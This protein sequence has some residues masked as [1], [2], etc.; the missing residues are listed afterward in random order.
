MTAENYSLKAPTSL[1]SLTRRCLYHAVSA[2][3]GSYSTHRQ[4]ALVGQLTAFCAEAK[5]ACGCAPE[6]EPV[7]TADDVQRF[8]D[9]NVT[10]KQF[11]SLL[12]G[13]LLRRS[14]D[15]PNL[16]ALQEICYRLYND[17]AETTEDGY[18]KIEMLPPPCSYKLWVIFNVLVG[19]ENSAL[20]GK[21]NFRDLMKRLYELSGLNWTDDPDELANK[22]GCLKFSEYLRIINGYFEKQHL[23]MPLTCEMIE[24]VYDEFVC[25]VQMKGYLIK[26]G[27]VRKNFKRRWFILQRTKL[28]YF[29]S[30][31]VLVKKGEI[32][33]DNTSE[34]KDVP[35]TK[36]FTYAFKLNCVVSGKPFLLL[37]DTQKD[38]HQ[39]MTAI[40]KVLVLTKLAEQ[41]GKDDLYEQSLQCFYTLKYGSPSLSLQVADPELKM[42]D[43]YEGFNK[44]NSESDEENQY[45]SSI[46]LPTLPKEDS[47]VS[48]SFFDGPIDVSKKSPAGTQSV[49]GGG[50]PTM[51]NDP[52]AG[53]VHSSLSFDEGDYTYLSGI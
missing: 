25:G 31:S 39:W 16:E 20:V 18:V 2:L 13:G 17:S 5:S 33:L 40:N 37:A 14:E 27:H 12:E 23:S 41:K 24:D 9:G 30:K 26:R 15:L 47:T 49:N 38:K 45:T 51:E 29:Q 32:A 44:D 11:C 34:V 46:T 36:K 52:P 50:A 35:D 22:E 42:L 1:P 28:T 10:V 3:H 7:V 43:H 21:D 48:G 6:S 4:T 8:A 53:P 19:R